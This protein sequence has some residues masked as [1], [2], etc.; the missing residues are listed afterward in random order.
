MV[1]PSHDPYKCIECFRTFDPRIPISHPRSLECKHCLCTE[2][3][4]EIICDLTRLKYSSIR[5]TTASN[6]T[7]KLCGYKTLVYSDKLD[8]FPVDFKKLKRLETLNLT[9]PGCQH[10]YLEKFCSICIMNF[11]SPCMITHNQMHQAKAMENKLEVLYRKLNHDSQDLRLETF[12]GK[13]RIGEHYQR[14]MQSLQSEYHSTLDTFSQRSSR[15]E[16]RLRH[17]SNTIMTEKDRLNQQMRIPNGRNPS[18]LARS[19]SDSESLIDRLHQQSNRAE[20]DILKSI[21]SGFENLTL[22][23]KNQTNPL[24]SIFSAGENYSNTVELSNTLSEL[25]FHNPG[26]SVYDHRPSTVDS[27]AQRIPTTPP[28]AKQYLQQGQ[29]TL[30][31]ISSSRQAASQ[32]SFRPY[33]PQQPP[34]S[35]NEANLYART[36]SPQHLSPLHRPSHFKN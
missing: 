21:T 23:K 19:I 33:N 16:N 17:H 24:P 28:V 31:A 29:P 2:C 13:K 30:P 4:R 20:L 35:P 12:T 1:Q 7:C 8:R 22:H 15:I 11:C 18:A 9:Q 3:L 25:N 26:E 5:P 32:K 27:A 10:S 14:L 36:L 6:L 34:P